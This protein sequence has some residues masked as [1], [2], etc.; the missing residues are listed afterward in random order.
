MPTTKKPIDEELVSLREEIQK[1]NYHYHALDEPIISDAEYD[2]LFAKLVEL[3]NQNPQLITP[4]SPTQRVGSEALSKFETV[5]HQT[6]MLS[7][8]NVFSEE[9]FIHFDNRLK[10]LLKSSDDIEYSCEPKFDG[11]A[12][13]LLY[14]DGRL[15]QGATRGDG[16]NGENITDNI[17]TVAS[18]PLKLRPGAP[19][20][21]E[22]R[23]EVYMPLAGFTEINKIA[24]QQSQ[25][26]FANPRNAAAGSLRQLDSKV[27]AKRPLAFYAY[28]ATSLDAKQLPENHFELLEK[29]KAWG[30]RVCPL[31]TKAKNAAAVLKFYHSLLNKRPSLDY[32]IDGVV[33]KV[34]AHALQDK[35]GY[36][37]RAPR[38]AVAFKFPA[39]EETTVLE[40]VDFQVGRTG[41]LT[42]VARLKPVKVGGV[43]VSNATLHNMDEINRKDVRVHDT[44]IVR[45]AG[46]VIPEVVKPI[47][48]KRPQNSKAISLPKKC[49]VCGSKVV[50]IE[51]IAAARCDGG[52][53]CHAQRIEAIKHFVSRKAMD[54]DGL[55][56]KLVEQLVNVGLV[57]TVADLYQLKVDDLAAMPRMAEKSATNIMN[58]LEASKK[59]SLA[60]FIYAL[61]IREVGEA[62]AQ[63]LTDHFATL[64]DLKSA[65][66]EALE[67]IPDIGPVSAQY[68]V[69]FFKEKT[70]LQVIQSLID[71]GIHWPKPAKQSSTKQ[72]LNGHVY[73]LTGT[74]SR[75]RDDIKAELIA[76]G[77]KV[78]GSISKSTTA[79]IV[80]EKPGSKLKKAMALNIPVLDEAQLVNLFEELEN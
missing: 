58:A 66:R 7:L 77:A 80:G 30:I 1:Y 57:Q 47:L 38:W 34:N 60:K 20:S 59:T 41:A 31:T 36:V 42:P 2:R 46:D 26:L 63:T 27:T 4:D 6:P 8:D 24:L 45:R 12:V 37:A 52:L 40:S 11:V 39:Q 18:I 67:N 32:E 33:I 48:E 56:Q 62:T 71:A 73:V 76:L 16:L 69:A 29:I 15:V 72:P 10:Q 53:I 35:L 5:Q 49:P 65:D 54:I 78:T 3:E 17:K 79:V 9:D 55:G 50:T 28:S 68:I 70:N 64:E 14:Q 75:S 43:M 44:V 51:G 23:G 21:L 25:K 74:L 19:K 61:G 13:S 22:V